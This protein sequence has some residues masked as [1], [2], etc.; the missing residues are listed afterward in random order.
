ME[1]NEK[2][3]ENNIESIKDSNMVYNIETT[4]LAEFPKRQNRRYYHYNEKD[5]YKKSRIILMAYE[6]YEENIILNK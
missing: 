4:G 2:K 1:T 6:I 5:K 3:L